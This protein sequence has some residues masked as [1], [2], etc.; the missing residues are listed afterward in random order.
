MG[1]KIVF[2]KDP[3]PPNLGTRNSPY[4]RSLTKFLCVHTQEGGRFGKIEGT[5]GKSVEICD[6]SIV[7]AYASIVTEDL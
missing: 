7:V 3:P 5:Q 6:A 4:L 1:D 2:Q